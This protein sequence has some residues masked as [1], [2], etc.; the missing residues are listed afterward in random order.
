MG[1]AH[2]VFASFER[3]GYIAGGGENSILM[4]DDI[5]GNAFKIIENTWNSFLKYP[6]PQAHLL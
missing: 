1:I 3:I 2:A 5:M 4:P 6:L